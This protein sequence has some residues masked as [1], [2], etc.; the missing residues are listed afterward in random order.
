M[1]HIQH[2]HTLQHTTTHYDSLQL[3]ATFSKASLLFNSIYKMIAE[4]IFENNFVFARPY[5]NLK[6]SQKSAL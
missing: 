6:D 5:L 1:Q 4:L 3:T 2:T